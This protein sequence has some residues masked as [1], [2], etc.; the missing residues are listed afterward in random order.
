M[1]RIVTKQAVGVSIVPYPF[2]VCGVVDF[3]MSLTSD[4]FIGAGTHGSSFNAFIRL[5]RAMRGFDR[6][7]FAAMSHVITS[8]QFRSFKAEGACASADDCQ[9]HAREI[10]SPI[11]RAQFNDVTRGV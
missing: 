6:A 10:A 5:Y 8:K 4:Y 2:E 7:T 1:H 9:K 3:E 11:F